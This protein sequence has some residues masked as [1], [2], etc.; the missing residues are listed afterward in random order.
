[1]KS[2]SLI[3]I[4]LCFSPLAWSSPWSD[5]YTP[6]WAQTCI[7]AEES[8]GL[9]LLA[10]Y[11]KCNSKGYGGYKNDLSFYYEKQGAGYVFSDIVQSAHIVVTDIGMDAEIPFELMGVCQDTMC[12]R[13]L[14]YINGDSKTGQHVA[15]WVTT[16]GKPW[17]DGSGGSYTVESSKDRRTWRGNRTQEMYYR[18]HTL[19]DDIELGGKVTNRFQDLFVMDHYVNRDG[20]D[21]PWTVFYNGGTAFHASF[22]VNGNVGSHG[23]TRLKYHESRL[24]NFLARHVGRNY[25]VET[26]Y[27]EREEMSQDERDSATRLLE[28][29]GI[30]LDA[31]YDLNQRAQNGD[32]DAADQLKWHSINNGGLY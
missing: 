28:R 3:S 27:T 9:G 17:T 5:G 29:A 18:L 4:I 7:Q 20:D 11:N 16:P 32:G 1:M 22:T 6:S 8:G 26:R 23:C 13:A 21:M 15:T 19:S 25:T 2:L 30:Q 12:Y 31:I 24:M 14:V 10:D